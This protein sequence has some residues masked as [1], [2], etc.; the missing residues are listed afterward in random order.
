MAC[1]TSAVGRMR[2]APSREARSRSSF[3]G[4]RSTSSAC[5]RRSRACGPRS[6]PARHVGLLR[7]PAVRP[8]PAR[9]PEDGRRRRALQALR[10]VVRHDVGARR[11]AVDADSRHRAPRPCVA[12]SLRG[13]LRVGRARAGSRVLAAGD[14]APQPSGR[15]FPF[16]ACGY[17]WLV[18]QEHSVEELDGS[19]LH[20]RYWLGARRGRR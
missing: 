19:S 14:A 6:P 20:E 17:R 11:R 16:R 13:G 2:F 18:V 7:L 9:Q 10:R 1:R 4:L 8:P 3:C 15:L 12:A 5:G